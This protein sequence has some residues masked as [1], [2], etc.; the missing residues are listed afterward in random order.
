MKTRWIVIVILSI[1]AIIL[2]GSGA[3]PL[4]FS[5]AV[6]GCNLQKILATNDIKHVSNHPIT[7][8]YYEKYEINSTST[9]GSRSLEWGYGIVEYSSFHGANYVEG[10]YDVDQ[11]YAQLKV[12]VDQ[13]GIPQEFQFRCTD[14]KN[15]ELI[16]LDSK[17]DDIL[18]YLQNKNCFEVKN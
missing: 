9:S 8:A 4:I 7:N 17:N 15:K 10:T 3:A 5:Q 12:T 11:S 16:L 1:T 13:C 18:Y 6:Y 14:S 2:L